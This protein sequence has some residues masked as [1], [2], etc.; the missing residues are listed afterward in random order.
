MSQLPPSCAQARETAADVAGHLADPARVAAV[1]ARAYD[2]APPALLLPGW[3]PSSLLLGHAGIAM[4]HARLA[5]DD[6]RSSAT[7]H[8]HLAAAAAAAAKAGPASAGELVLPVLLQ[9]ATS[10]GYARL[11]A[12]SAE[13]HASYVAAVTKQL[14]AQ[15]RVNGPGLSYA[16]YDTIAGLAGQG[17]V[18]LL[19]AQHGDGRSADV[20]MDVLVWLTGLAQP[21]RVAGHEVP[22]WWCAPERYVVERDRTVY[23]R[24]DF[25]VGAAHGICGPLSLLALAQ[26]AGYRVPGMQ[27]ALRTMADWVAEKE[28]KDSTGARWPGRVAYDDETVPAPG[29]PRSSAGWCYGTAGIAWALH[30]AG[31]AL[32]DEALTERAHSAVREAFRRPLET[33]MREDLTLCHGRS[34]LLHAG[35]RTAAATGDVTLWADVDAMAAAIAAGF[36]AQAAFGYRQVLPPGTGARSLDA[37][38]VL[39]GAAGVALALLS[40]ADAR[41]GRPAARSGESMWDAALLMS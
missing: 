19:N 22:G 2:S 14:T 31:E 37:P 23:P 12:R 36:D 6:P 39:D 4:L 35:V 17:R 41:A 9:T 33:G 34:G 29:E 7:A 20:L 11:L 16:D 26:L 38:G 3:R 40:Y 8:A 10:G 1:T 13:V 28:H 25:N 27:D 24:G 15:R 21:V 5:Q 30:L 18:L 32:A